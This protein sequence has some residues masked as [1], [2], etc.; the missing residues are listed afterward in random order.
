MPRVTVVVPRQHCLLLVRDKSVHA[1][2][3]SLVLELGMYGVAYKVEEQ[4]GSLLQSLEEAAK[5]AL[6][7]DADGVPQL[8][9][10]DQEIRRP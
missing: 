2:L 5:A 7:G 4:E 8:E 6:D 9:H 1:K 10:T 3:R